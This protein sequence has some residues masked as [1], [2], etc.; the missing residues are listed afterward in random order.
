MAW[1]SSRMAARKGLGGDV[2]VDD[3]ELGIIDD[4]GVAFGRGR[5]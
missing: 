5:I 4:E 3:A 2:L 1:A